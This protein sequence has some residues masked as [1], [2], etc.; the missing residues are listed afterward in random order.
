[1]NFISDTNAKSVLRGIIKTAIMET[2]MMAEVEAKLKQVQSLWPNM[3]KM[4]SVLTEY[5]KPWALYS[6]IAIIKETVETFK[7]FSLEWVMMEFVETDKGWQ[8]KIRSVNY[9]RHNDS[10]LLVKGQ[11]PTITIYGHALERLFQRGRIITWPEVRKAIF[12]TMSTTYQIWSNCDAD[13][14]QIVTWSELGAFVGYMEEMT[15]NGCGAHYA[16]RNIVLKTFYSD[17]VMNEKVKRVRQHMM[18][19][20]AKHYKKYPSS[21]GPFNQAAWLQD[22]RKYHSWMCEPPKLS[23]EE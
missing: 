8:I 13:I 5:A 20:M 18:I 17:R 11:R 16:K 3:S 12:E 1:M 2:P 21:Y 10:Q 7:T 6:N 23:E 9:T 14:H 22:V 19:H 4:R 15:D